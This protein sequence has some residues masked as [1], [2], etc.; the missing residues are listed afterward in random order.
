MSSAEP[1]ETNSIR[2]LVMLVGVAAILLLVALRTGGVDIGPPGKAAVAVAP[3]G[4]AP[5]LVEV[6]DP[7]G[8]IALP[9]PA[10]GVLN[11]SDGGPKIL[12]ASGGGLEVEVFDSKGPPVRALQLHKL[13]VQNA[14]ER[15]DTVTKGDRAEDER[16]RVEVQLSIR[17]NAGLQGR[18]R[19]LLRGSRYL[20]VRAVGPGADAVVSGLRL[21]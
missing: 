9:L 7:A 1:S 6:V 2:W 16:G 21:P 14:T 4:P 15:G 8:R 10:K 20:Q 18:V 19:Y 3:V 5:K 12:T 17:T 11:W 13:A